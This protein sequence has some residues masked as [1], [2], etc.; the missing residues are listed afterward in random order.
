MNERIAHQLHG[1][2]EELAKGIGEELTVPGFPRL[3][4]QT[5]QHDF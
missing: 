3:P 4:L 5:L 2:G 1:F